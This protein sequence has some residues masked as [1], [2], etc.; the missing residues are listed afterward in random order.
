[1]RGQWL[2]MVIGLGVLGLVL[3]MPWLLGGA[4]LSAAVDIATMLALACLWNLL[5]GYAGIVSIGQQAFVGIGGYALFGLVILGGLSPLAAIPL[6]GVV[7][8]L[9]AVPVATLLFRLRGPHFA[10]G[11][12]VVA[13]VFRLL[14]AQW[15]ALGGGSGQSLPVAAMR[16]IA[17]DR[18]GRGVVTYAIAVLLAAGSCLLAWLLLR[19]RHGLALTALRDSE[20][21]AG[22]LGVAVRPLQRAVYVIVA[23]LTGMAGAVIFFAKIRISP[24]AAFNVVDWTADVIFIVVVGG[25]ATLEGPFIGAALFFL[26]RAAFADY[27]PYY[28]IALGALAAGVMVTM[29]EGLCGVLKR[30]GWTMFPLGRRLGLPHAAAQIE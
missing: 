11:S 15:T 25:I 23:C 17:P 29:P 19:S 20:V 14:F 7:A 10:I 2:R 12:W 13:E 16:A 30:R 4:N 9:A 26:F 1:M 3:A 6:A 22:G 21:A 28:M 27:G 8:A 18:A 5:A 24:D